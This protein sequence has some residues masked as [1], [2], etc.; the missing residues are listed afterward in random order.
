V[1]VREQNPEVGRDES[2]APYWVS[3]DSAVEV[4]HADVLVVLSRLLADGRRFRGVVLDPPYASG[5]ARS[6]GLR[7]TG[8]ESVE[9]HCRTAVERL[10]ASIA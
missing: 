4:Y 2:V 7:V 6:L 1:R 9:G 8:I 3:P 10:A 5:S